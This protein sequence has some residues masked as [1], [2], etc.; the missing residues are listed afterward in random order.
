MKLKS[1]NLFN[2]TDEDNK[3]DVKNYFSHFGNSLMAKQCK[4]S[5]R[6]KLR[7]VAFAVY[8]VSSKNKFEFVK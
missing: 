4:N 1:N 7:R 6:L 2:M 8:Y 3:C 5:T